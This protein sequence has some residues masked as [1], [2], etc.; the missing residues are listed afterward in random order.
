MVRCESAARSGPAADLSSP[1]S[2]FRM[3]V[4]DA[5]AW[6]AVGGTTWPVQRKHVL[7]SARLVRVASPS[8]AAVASRAPRDT[9]DA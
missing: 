5:V 1:R 9:R 4:A 7:I 8:S 2:P 6:E 3:I